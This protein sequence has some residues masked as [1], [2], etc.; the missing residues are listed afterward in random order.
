M[1]N[2][3]K[4][5]ICCC[6]LGAFSGSVDATDRP[7]ILVIFTD[8]HGWADLGANGVDIQCDDAHRRARRMADGRWQPMCRRSQTVPI[9]WVSDCRI[10]AKLRSQATL[11]HRLRRP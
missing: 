11:G 9:V 4:S 1:K 8:D 6:V 10:A 5:L 7:N 3:F 2:I